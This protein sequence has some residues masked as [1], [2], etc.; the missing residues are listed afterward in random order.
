MSYD[1]V[2]QLQARRTRILLFCMQLTSLQMPFNVLSFK[3]PS[4]S[5][6]LNTA[7]IKLVVWYR[8]IIPGP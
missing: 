6:V 4:G 8:R 7:K 2:T 1:A 5:Y 3:A